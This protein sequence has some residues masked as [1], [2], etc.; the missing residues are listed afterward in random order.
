M[1]NPNVY[2]VTA[3]AH[4]IGKAISVSLL[5][6]GASV[7]CTW[8][9]DRTEAD[10][11]SSAYPGSVLLLAASLEKPE[12]ASSLV[13]SAYAWKGRLDGI[14]NNASSFCPLPFEE[15][16][17]EDFRLMLDIHAA[18]PFFLAQAYAQRL[19]E[20]KG[21]VVNI[22]DSLALRGNGKKAAYRIAKG[23]LEAETSVLASVLGPRI[24]VNAVAPGFVKPHGERETAFFEKEEANLPLGTCRDEGSVASAVL[25]LLSSSSVTGETIHTD[26]G[27]HLV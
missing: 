14:V 2:L 12:T 4:G 7:V 18:T 21:C 17:V 5:E 23:A 20:G 26:G 16:T 1:E 13:R 15:T 25:Y 8:H 11:L 10:A 9:T 19:G 3:G 6:S 27:R 22:T 24:R